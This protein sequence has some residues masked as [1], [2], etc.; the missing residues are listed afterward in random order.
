MKEVS[1]FTCMGKRKYLPSRILY[2]NSQI[3]KAISGHNII[4]KP[5]PAIR[6]LKMTVSRRMKPI[7]VGNLQITERREM[8]HLTELHNS[9]TEQLWLGLLSSKPF[10]PNMEIT[11]V[12]H[13]HAGPSSKTFAATSVIAVVC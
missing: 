3:I 9:D 12:T 5:L 13:A 11:A 1:S 4:N 10:S 8:K 6:T 2:V 7:F